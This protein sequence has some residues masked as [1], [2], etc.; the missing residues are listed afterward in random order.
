[1]LGICR[2]LR[3]RAVPVSAYR[4]TVNPDSRSVVQLRRP[5]C[6]AVLPGQRCGRRFRNDR[7]RGCDV[8][9]C[10]GQFGADCWS[11]IL[12][13]LQDSDC[14][15]TPKAGFSG[16]LMQLGRTRCVV[17]GRARST[18]LVPNLSDRFPLRVWA[19]TSR[20]ICP[21][22]YG[23]GTT[24]AEPM[25]YVSP[26]VNYSL[27]GASAIE[28][29]NHMSLYGRFSESYTRFGVTFHT[30]EGLCWVR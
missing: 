18:E 6:M 22:R 4:S 17:G 3:Y 14:Q 26:K 25:V 10:R 23:L 30:A 12:G 8:R 20:T 2:R 16:F 21:S 9:E 5:G 11:T 15:C 24:S 27:S 13:R 19:E 28:R 29:I 7:P 1:M